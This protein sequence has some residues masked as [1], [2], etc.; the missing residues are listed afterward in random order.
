[1]DRQSH[2]LLQWTGKVTICYNGQAKSRIVTMDR[3]SHELLQWTDKVTNCYNGQTKSRIVTMDRRSHELLQWTDKVTNCYNGQTKSRIVTM[4]R[5]SHE[6]LQW[7]DKVTNCYNGQTKSRI[8]IL[9]AWQDWMT[10][11]LDSFTMT[12]VW[13]FWCTPRTTVSQDVQ[14]RFPVQ[15]AFAKFLFKIKGNFKL[16]QCQYH[17]YSTPSEI[18]LLILDRNLISEGQLHR[19]S[20]LHVLWYSSPLWPL[21]TVFCWCH[22]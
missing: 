13:G 20:G 5:Q 15:L 16:I 8:V 11:F 18:S 9:F 12:L 14:T 2:E 1:M 10:L 17:G 3:Q 4:D 21:K 19:K 22:L 7:T 6:L